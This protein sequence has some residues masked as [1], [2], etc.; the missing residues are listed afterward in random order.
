MRNESS[1]ELT[2]GDWIVIDSDDEGEPLWL[3]RIMSNSDWGG[4]GVC[5]N[6]T[7]RIKTYYNGTVL[8]QNDVGMYV[9]WYEK[10]DLIS[11]DLDYHY[12]EQSP[13]P[14]CRTMNT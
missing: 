10:I 9:M 4:Q 13:S 2:V 1:M 6:T 7:M 12:Q 5:K 3:G 11:D 8:Q 14:P